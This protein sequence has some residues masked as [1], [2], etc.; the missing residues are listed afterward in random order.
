MAIFKRKEHVTQL[1]Y[2]LN[3]RCSNNQAEQLAIVKTLEAIATLHIEENSP[4][5]AAIITDSRIALD[6]IKN[7]NNHSHLI[8]EI[9]KRLLNLERSDWTV[10]FSRVKAHTGILGNELADQLAKAAARDNHETVSYNRV[11]MSTLHRE[12]EE[13]KLNWKKRWKKA[14]RLPKPNNSFLRY[15]IDLN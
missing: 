6:S 5:T 14:Q 2:K 8:E 10:V 9:R 15:Q 12:L 4:R 7:L 3:N 13:T 1:K 11:P